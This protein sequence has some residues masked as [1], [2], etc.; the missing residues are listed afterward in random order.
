MA[1]Y[2]DIE[3][4]L[5]AWIQNNHPGVAVGNRT[6]S[7]VTGRVV[8]VMKLGGPRGPI[9]DSP[10]VDI[11]VYAPTR[12]QALALAEQIDEELQPRTRVGDAI[13]DFVRTDTSPRQL[14]WSN[15]NTTRYSAT[16]SLSLRR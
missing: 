2:Q 10:T 7:T 8:R 6:P 14:P 9:T 1:Y 4:N 13:I 3:A 16:Y 15:S 5:V 11:D 12:D